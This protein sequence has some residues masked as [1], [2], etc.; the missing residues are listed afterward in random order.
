MDLDKPTRE[1]LL[2]F[3]SLTFK[4]EEYYQLLKEKEERGNEEEEIFI[5]M[6]YLRE[7][8]TDGPLNLSHGPLAGY[9][10]WD[11]LPMMFWEWAFKGEYLNKHVG[12]D[13]IN[14]WCVSTIW[15]GINH[16]FF[17][18]EPPIIFETMIFKEDENWPYHEDLEG[19]QERYS[20]YEEAL[21]GHEKACEEIK[22]TTQEIII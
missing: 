9:Y 2:L 21:K 16:N 4:A 12:D 15:L 8:L 18:K 19:Y 6:D 17:F 13:I 20:T 1:T 3:D 22:N 14:G 7:T 5:L 10:D 11:G